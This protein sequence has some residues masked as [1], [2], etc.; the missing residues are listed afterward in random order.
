MPNAIVPAS[1]APSASMSQARI[2]VAPRGRA[3]RHHAFE[4]DHASIYGNLLS[5]SAKKALASSPRIAVLLLDGPAPVHEA[6]LQDQD[7][8]V[9]E[10]GPVWHRRLVGQVALRPDLATTTA[11]T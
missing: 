3:P 10:D 11:M 6:A 9:E 7:Q 1:V 2:S 8:V 4:G 5:R